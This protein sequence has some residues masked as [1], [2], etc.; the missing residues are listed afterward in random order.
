MLDNDIYKK[1][2]KSRISMSGFPMNVHQFGCK[3][4]KHIDLHTAMCET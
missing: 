1:T 2:H 4:E 3:L